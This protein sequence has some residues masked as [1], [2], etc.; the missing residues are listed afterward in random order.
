MVTFPLILLGRKKIIFM[1]LFIRA[2]GYVIGWMTI[3]WFLIF[4]IISAVCVI[5][6]STTSCDEFKDLLM[7]YFN[8]HLDEKMY[9]EICM[10]SRGG[11]IVRHSL[12]NEVNTKI[13]LLITFFSSSDISHDFDVFLLHLFRVFWI[14]MRSWSNHSK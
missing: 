7:N 13:L 10:K 5:G 12:D 8:V 9:D 11:K 4:T 3:I 1:L 14:S 2:L 6:L